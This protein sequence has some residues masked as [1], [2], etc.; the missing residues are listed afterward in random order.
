MNNIKALETIRDELYQLSHITLILG[1]IV[2][3]R[4]KAVGD[5]ILSDESVQYSIDH[6]C[7]RLTALS[8]MMDET[9]LDLILKENDLS[10]SCSS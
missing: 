6:L 1:Q 2:Q 4:G 7:D 3:C 10:E 9:C 5:A 8:K